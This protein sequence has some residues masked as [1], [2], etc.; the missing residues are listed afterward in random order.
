MFCTICG[1]DADNTWRFCQSCGA[2]LNKS[3]DQTA[4]SE[5]ILEESET[6]D[7]PE[8]FIPDLE[9]VRPAHLKPWP[10]EEPQDVPPDSSPEKVV[11]GDLGSK[12]YKVVFA[13]LLVIVLGSVGALLQQ[14]FSTQII[15]SPTAAESSQTNE[16]PGNMACQALEGATTLILEAES[17]ERMQ[18]TPR[19]IQR[20]DEVR[21]AIKGI[22]GDFRQLLIVQAANLG[23]LS[24][25][26]IYGDSPLARRGWDVYLENL[27]RHSIYCSGEIARSTPRPIE[28]QEVFHVVVSGDNLTA[29]AEKYGVDLG[30][31]AEFNE[32]DNPS[33]ISVGQV[34]KIPNA[35]SDDNTTSDVATV[36]P[37]SVP[38][39]SQ[40]SSKLSSYDC[41][42][43]ESN[44][45]MVRTVFTEGT[46]TPSQ[47]AAILQSAASK[48]DVVA[49]NQS[50]SRASW[51]SK[52]SE[53]S[54]GLRGYILNGSPT[55]GEQLLDQL[56]NN[57]NLS[58][59]FC[60]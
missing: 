38:S 22:E 59:Q 4:A 43:V 6:K 35:N 18:S 40:A 23:D 25:G 41:A 9:L 28:V 15:D 10:E 60:P 29:I 39:A 46:A 12:R 27:E 58:G 14:G 57:F 52:M 13:A 32:I 44:I 34:I 7:L 20:V 53:L 31:L 47:I 26:I 49:I 24:E 33:N 30:L 11:T 36:E 21:R 51:L 1:N 56:G 16:S 48:W 50:G 37:T 5:E 2:E 3:Q 19:L 42:V 54:L 55:N 8:E 17:L 45:T